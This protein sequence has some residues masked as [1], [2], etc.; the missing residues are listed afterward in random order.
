MPPPKPSL[1]AQGTYIEVRLVEGY[2]IYVISVVVGAELHSG[3][4]DERPS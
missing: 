3:L 1:L 2:E 4:R